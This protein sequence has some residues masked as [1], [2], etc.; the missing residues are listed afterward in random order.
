MC[1]TPQ[2]VQKVPFDLRRLQKIAGG[3]GHTLFLTNES[4]IY[5]CGW[6]HRGQLGSASTEDLSEI[7]PVLDIDGTNPM[8][9]IAHIAAGWDSSAAIDRNGTLFV[10]GSNAFGQLGFAKSDVS[11]ACRPIRLELPNGERVAQMCFGLRHLAILTEDNQV[12]FT[13]RIKFQSECIRVVYNSTDFWKLNFNGGDIQLI[14][15]GQNHFLCVTEGKDGSR[16]YGFGDNRFGQ[17]ETILL[18]EK[19]SGLQSGWTNNGVL[20][21]DGQVSLWGRN[22][23]G[24]LGVLDVNLKGVNKLNVGR[25]VKWLHLGSEH[26]MIITDGGSVFT[27]GWNEHGNC[28]NG[29]VDNV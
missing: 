2:L 13:G 12:Y 10:W 14:A 9:D 3:G 18:N 16:V 21:D 4:K 1:E 23:Y 11:F 20:T 7:G 8:H 26:G 27:W 22:S 17:A 6:N 25:C 28:G 24:Q 19:V 15:T 5:S 29:L